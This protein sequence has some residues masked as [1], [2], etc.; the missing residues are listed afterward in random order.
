M[1]EEHEQPVPS[2]FTEK[3]ITTLGRAAA[4]LGWADRGGV[5]A[6]LSDVYSKMHNWALAVMEYKKKQKL[7]KD[8]SK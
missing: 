5:D 1:I 7:A 4:D 8:D 6:F 3:E 2:P